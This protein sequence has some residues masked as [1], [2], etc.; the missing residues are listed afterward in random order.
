MP[1][2]GAAW[3]PMAAYCIGELVLCSAPIEYKTSYLAAIDLPDIEYL[4]WIKALFG[5]WLGESVFV[6]QLRNRHPRHFA[7]FS[8]KIIELSMNLARLIHLQLIEDC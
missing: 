2:Q 4:H 7:G 3:Q 5:S 1:Q 8:Y 6:T